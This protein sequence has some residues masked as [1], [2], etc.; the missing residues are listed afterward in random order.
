MEDDIDGQTN[1]IVFIGWQLSTIHNKY[2]VIIMNNFDK[3]VWILLSVKL[4]ANVWY[5][6]AT[7][8]QY[9]SESNPYIF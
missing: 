7:T 1:N 3:S 2:C 5:Y 4:L 6:G 8:E 9:S